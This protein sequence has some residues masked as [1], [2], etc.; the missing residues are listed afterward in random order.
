MS[1]HHLLMSRIVSGSIHAVR[2][3]IDP[4]ARRERV[5]TSCDAKPMVWPVSRT[6]ARMAASISVILI[7]THF[8]LCC[9]AVRVVVPVAP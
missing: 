3:A 7:V 9:T 8:S 5:L 6:T 2:S 4:P 1:L